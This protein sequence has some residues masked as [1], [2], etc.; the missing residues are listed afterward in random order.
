MAKFFS[1]SR[2]Y[3]FSGGTSIRLLCL[4][5]ALFAGFFTLPARA[6]DDL[7]F[8]VVGIKEDVTADN[9]AAARDQAFVQAQQNAFRKLAE[10]LLSDE[11]ARALA[12]PEATDISA[13]IKNFEITDEK[14]APVRYAAT[15][16]FRFKGD[17]VHE[18]LSGQGKAFTDVRSKPVLVV[19]FYQQGAQ[20]VLWGAANPWLAAWSR[21]ESYQGLVPV[22]VPIGD[23]S[24]VADMTGDKALTY[25]AQNL[26]DLTMRYGAGEA[27]ILVAAPGG[28]DEAA[29]PNFVPAALS[30]SLYRTDNGAP[31]MTQKIQVGA[32]D[33]EDGETIFDAGVRKVRETLLHDWKSKTMV[34]PAQGN[35]LKAHVSFSSLQEWADTQKALSRVQGVSDVQLVSLTPGGAQIDLVFQGSEDRLRL[36]LA[37]ADMTLS[38]PQ[39]SFT[40][41]WGASSPLVYELYLNRYRR[42]PP[43][44]MGT[45]Y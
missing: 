32:A 10:R 36:A 41:A 15:Y 22:I 14:I 23:V 9:A 31:E 21:I 35:N 17:A 39:V 6:A 40:G 38:S 11:D 18:F 44:G 20:T 42:A 28:G 19:P 30:V 4:F 12:M 26:Y 2:L 24:D 43:A 34:G 5:F 33:A 13:M 45:R 7:A 27:I 1:F 3:S 8:T 29:P 37:Q 16:T 25:Q